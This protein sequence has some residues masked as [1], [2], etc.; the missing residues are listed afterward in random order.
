MGCG[1]ERGNREIGNREIKNLEAEAARR[2]ESFQFLDDRFS[3]F[4]MLFVGS[5]ACHAGIQ[6]SPF[7]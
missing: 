6:K 2:F 3:V 4:T 5:A 7:A 1:D